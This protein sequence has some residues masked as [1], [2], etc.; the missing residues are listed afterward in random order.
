M[1]PP[2]LL[3]GWAKIA[4]APT[5]KSRRERS[6]HDDQVLDAAS[7]YAGAGRGIMF[8][9]K[10]PI[11]YQPGCGIGRPTYSNR[12]LM[13][14]PKD[15]DNSGTWV[16]PTSAAE[17]M[18]ANAYVDQATEVVR[19]VEFAPV[20]GEKY[21]DA[22]WHHSDFV[23]GHPWAHPDAQRAVESFERE[24]NYF[25]QP[26]S[27]ELSMESRSEFTAAQSKADRVARA[28][29]DSAEPPLQGES[30][31]GYRVRLASQFQKHSKHQ[32]RE[33]GQ[34]RRP[35]FAGRHRGWHFQ[36]RDGGTPGFA[37][38]APMFRPD[39]CEPS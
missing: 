37:G 23:V 28:F 22:S 4:A 20:L 17:V 19:C 34:D 15:A 9:A 25:D 36:R 38:T 27:G 6:D 8:V 35:R 33:L 1:R 2:P 5:T 14:H 26:S 32:G 7:L 10:Q 21:D 3:D 13:M 30:L 29:G 12:F 24:H 18:P 39:S 16:L 11:D 31:L